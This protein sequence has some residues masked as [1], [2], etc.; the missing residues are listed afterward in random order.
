MSKFTEEQ[1]K[2]LEKVI[3]LGKDEEERPC[4]LKV[5]CSI[6]GNVWGD[7]EGDIGGSVRGNVEHNINGIVFGCVKGNVWRDIEGYVFGNIGG[8][9]RGDVLGDI[10]G[11]VFGN[12][13]GKVFG[14]IESDEKREESRDFTHWFPIPDGTEMD[15][16]ALQDALS[17]MRVAHTR[18][19]RA[20]LALLQNR[21]EDA[22]EHVLGAMSAL[23][24][25]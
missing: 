11:N 9:V 21:H 19:Q 17:S 12:I 24:T 3:K 5:R 2:F 15:A 4:I 10:E 6:K 1:L 20:G 18:L 13:K 14:V 7:V 22:S 8:S 23:V 25:G 16:L